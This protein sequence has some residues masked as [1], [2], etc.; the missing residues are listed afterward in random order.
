[1]TAPIQCCPYLPAAYTA[2]LAQ[3]TGHLARL[4]AA[5]TAA[6]ETAAKRLT[7]AVCIHLEYV[8]AV[9][10]APVRA[11][12]DGIALECPEC[13]PAAIL[14]GHRLVDA[15]VADVARKC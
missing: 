15:A 7:P 8:C 13:V 10:E 6:I 3:H 4:E 9:F 2:S 5:I 14:L 12:I 1:V 11:L